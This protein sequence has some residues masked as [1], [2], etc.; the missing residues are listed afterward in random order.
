[1][2]VLD[3]SYEK[4]RKASLYDFAK[5]KCVSP[6]PTRKVNLKVDYVFF[7]LFFCICLFLL[8]MKKAGGNAKCAGWS[9]LSCVWQHLNT[10]G[11]LGHKRSS[12]ALASSGEWRSPTNPPC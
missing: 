6:F 8:L 11:S 7:V 9:G 10:L 12:C 2:Q 4:Q 1:M 3:R 5:G